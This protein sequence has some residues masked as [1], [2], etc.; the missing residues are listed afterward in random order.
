[1]KPRTRQGELERLLSFRACPTCEYDLAT[2]EGTRGCHYGACPYLPEALD[3]R[4]PTCQYNFFTDDLQPACGAP[5]SCEFALTEARARVDA[6][7]YW[8]AHQPKAS[9][10]GSGGS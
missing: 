8:L 10:P 4:C 2:G 7:T 1:M 9:A 5:P 6:L 3:T